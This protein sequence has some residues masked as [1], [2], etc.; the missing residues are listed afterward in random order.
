V[1]GPKLTPSALDQ[2]FHAIPPYLSSDP[3]EPACFYDP[4]DYT[5]VKDAE[6]SWWDQSGVPPSR[7]QTGCWRMWNGGLRYGAG[8]WPGGNVPPQDQSD[9]CNNYNGGAIFGSDF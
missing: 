6:A 1:A 7:T 3:Q 2:G 5:C 8:R 9:P 4:G